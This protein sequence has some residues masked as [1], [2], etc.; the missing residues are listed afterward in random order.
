MPNMD[1][2]NELIASR[3]AAKEEESSSEAAIRKA[4]ANLFFD[5]NSMIEMLAEKRFPGDPAA[6][7]RYTMMDGEL[8][9]EDDDGNL[10]PEFSS[11]ED[12]GMYDKY[13]VPNIVPA[14]TLVADMGGG[15]GGASMGFQ[16]GLEIARATGIK[17]PVAVGALT[18]GGASL[19]GMFG[20]L[21]VGGTQ[22]V[23]RELLLDQY[24]NLPPEEVKAAWDDL[25]IVG[26]VA[27]G[28]GGGEGGGKIGQGF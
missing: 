21:A 1:F 9:Y 2:Y 22:R 14:S 15:M 8:V 27:G 20:N 6:A 26:V 24:Y 11:L 4:Q 12:A 17:H 16:K 13:F 7:L 19:G 3:G 28:P 25:L 18:L 23:G 5:E 10:V